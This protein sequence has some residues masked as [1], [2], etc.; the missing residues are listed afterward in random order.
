[1]STRF[2]VMWLILLIGGC[3]HAPRRVDCDG[4]LQPINPSTPVVR[5][6]PA[7]VAP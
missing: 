2:A 6:S 4:H 7:Q 1:M 3:S 5:V